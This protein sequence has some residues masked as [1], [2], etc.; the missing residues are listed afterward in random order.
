MSESYTPGSKCVWQRE[1]PP[2]RLAERSGCAA[3]V[4][5]STNRPVYFAGE[6]TEE[7]LT[8]RTI[9]SFNGLCLVETVDKLGSWWMGNL[10]TDGTIRTWGIYGPL[11]DAIDSL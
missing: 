8:P 9:I 6:G 2:S 7:P 1:W 4:Y 5:L 11:E 10:D 3:V